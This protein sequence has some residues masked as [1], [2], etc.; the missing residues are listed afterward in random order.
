MA[1][2]AAVTLRP[3][4]EWQAAME[5]EDG[6]ETRGADVSKLSFPLGIVVQIAVTVISIGGAVYTVKADIGKIQ[7]QMEA[8]QK[9]DALQN[10]LLEERLAS[11]REDI[12]EMKRRLELVQLQYQQLRETVIET[13]PRR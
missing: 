3:P 10:Q 7:T 6:Q 2:D 12:T 9:I 11:Q 8:Q 5:R 1:S 4:D 13:R